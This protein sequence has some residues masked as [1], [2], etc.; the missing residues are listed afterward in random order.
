MEKLATEGLARINLVYK[1]G[2]LFDGN[3]DG[4]QVTFDR[5]RHLRNLCLYI[6]MNLLVVSHLIVFFSGDDTLKNQMI[7]LRLSK[8]GFA[9]SYLNLGNT[10]L[11]LVSWSINLT[12]FNLS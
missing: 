11:F 3:F 9:E 4:F 2:G 5:T 10:T 12:K 1:F 8:G 7:Y 6:A